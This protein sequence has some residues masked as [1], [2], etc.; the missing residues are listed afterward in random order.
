MKS[1]LAIIIS[2][3]YLER[4]KRKSFIISTLLMPILMIG[5]MLAPALIMAFSTPDDKTVAVVDQ[6]PEQIGRKLEKEAELT[7]VDAG[8]DYKAAMADEDYDAVL[9]INKDAV[10]RPDGIRLYSREAAS[11]QAESAISGQL[12]SIIE[13]ERLKAYDIANLA[14]IM[15]EL[16]VDV[17][18]ETFRITDGEDASET[19]SIA[20]Y[21]IGIIMSLMLYTF[22]MLYG[23]MVTTSII[24][25]KSNRVLEIVVSSVSPN[26]L[27]M[28]KIVGIGLVAITQIL[29][30]G[31]LLTGCS[32][33]IMPLVSNAAVA[34]GD[35][36]LDLGM[37]G[38]PWYIAELFGY[39]ALF[40]IGG[41]LFYSSIYA[42]VGSA[43]DNIQ[44]ASQ[45]LSIAI[46]PIILGLLLS[47]Q[48]AQDPSSGLAFWASMIPLTSPMVMMSRIPFGIPGW[49]ILLSLVILYA[50]FVGMVWIAAKIY[51][52]GIFM[53]GK[54]PTVVELIRWARYK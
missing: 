13:K 2:R 21:L 9:V 25:E 39:I 7:F 1:P 16:D 14:Q 37:L 10:S 8:N 47:M 3:E 12:E 4:V 18:L 28:G 51:R 35:G 52:V 19:S 23:Q 43:V 20:S 38:S 40:L 11:M 44:D 54:K 49:Q 41:Y 50:S 24:D 53:Y 32:F 46:I 36:A 6:T 17:T 48:A 26:A 30:W 5:L 33:W 31:V 22:I 34:A 27:M 29:I 42:A 45:L 15:K